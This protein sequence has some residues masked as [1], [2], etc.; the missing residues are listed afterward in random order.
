MSNEIN[1]KTKISLE[2]K[3]MVAMVI[4]LA[5]VFSV[6]FSL[7]ADIATARLLPTPEVTQEEIDYQN[8]IITN[9]I[10]M[11]QEDLSEIKASISKIEDRL[12]EQNLE[13]K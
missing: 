12:Y 11:I 2:T 6:Y 3:D 7:K 8:I 1:N 4:F 5:S 9:N 13:T 10:L